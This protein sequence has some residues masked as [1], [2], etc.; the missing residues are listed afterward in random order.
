MASSPSGTKTK[1]TW[2]PYSRS[3]DATASPYKSLRLGWVIMIT[4]SASSIPS[5]HSP[6]RFSRLGEWHLDV[7]HPP[8]NRGGHEADEVA[9]HTP[10]ECQ[11]GCVA[12]NLPIK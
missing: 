1:S 12:V 8:E 4:R 7:W 5:S 2:R 11:Q 10:S 6:T 9:E 3:P